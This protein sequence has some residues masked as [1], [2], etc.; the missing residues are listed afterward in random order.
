L[1]SASPVQGPKVILFADFSESSEDFHYQDDLFRR[2]NNGNYAQGFYDPNG[3]LRGDGALSVRLGGLDDS[4]ILGMSGG[5]WRR[6]TVAI[7]SDITIELNFQLEQ[8]ANYNSDERSEALCSIDGILIGGTNKTDYVAQLVGNGFGGG[9]QLI[10]YKSVT[11]KASK[12]QAG[13]HEIA[14]GGYNNKKTDED[15][16]TWIRIDSVRI[17]AAPSG[18]TLKASKPFQADD[19][20]LV[21]RPTLNIVLNA[22]FDE[23]AD[24]FN[25]LDNAFLCADNEGKARGTYRPQGGYEGGGLLVQLGGQDAFSYG[26]DEVPSSVDVLGSSGGWQRG[27]TLGAP[28]NVMLS[29][30]YNMSISGLFEPD[31]YSEVLVGIDGLKTD[32]IA[33]LVGAA[34]SYGALQRSTGWQTATLDLGLLSA[35]NHI[36]TIGGYS[37]KTTVA[38]VTEIHFDDVRVLYCNGEGI[39]PIDAGNPLSDALVPPAQGPPPTVAQVEAPTSNP[40]STSCDI[41]LYY[42]GRNKVLVCRSGG[43]EV[44][45]SL[46]DLRNDDCYGYC[47]E[48]CHGPLKCRSLEPLT[49]RYLR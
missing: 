24:G 47:N 25:Y 5:W 30:R 10:G 29:F 22:T 42:C 41:D 45:V 8:A 3:G 18:R 9:K 20:T 48:P 17:V 27:F 44:C 43:L 21:Q 7:D 35:G 28:K 11:L 12:L 16:V 34:A 13:S 36:V 23:D 26:D 39:S 32:S 14:V 49:R 19:R 2:T 4:R 31:E 33:T 46:S 37:N 6:F 15:E 1:P 38:E 40:R